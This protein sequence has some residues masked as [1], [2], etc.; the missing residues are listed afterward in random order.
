[1]EPTNE[2]TPED[3]ADV[4]ELAAAAKAADG[5]PPLN[6]EATL[7][8]VR[9]DALHWLLR[10][11]NRLCGYAQWQPSNA[12]GQL[13]VH[14]HH[15]RAQLGTALLGGLRRAAQP[16]VW[17]FGTLAP[18]RAFA[19]ARGLA[20]V[21]GLTMMRRALADEPN[22]VPP[23]GI[24]L[25]GFTAADADAFIALN[26]A[27]FAHHPE[28]GHFTA[29]DLQTR[30]AEAWW[31]PE[32]LILAIEDDQLR[33]FHWTKRHDAATGEVYVLGVAPDA[34]R[35]GLGRVLLQ[36]GLTQLTRDGATQVILYVDADNETALALYRKAGFAVVHTDTLY[37]PTGS[38]VTDA[39]RDR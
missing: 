39:V 35:R 2:L 31:D 13:V 30:Q 10:D 8:L 34:G 6:E 3:R 17:A 15:R 9:D 28:Q 38:P 21:R 14:P 20:P 33:G 7:A 29:A 18:A 26:A 27:A 23:N 11:G 1:M 5:T 12:T 37:G 24:T 32:G 22:P 4:I 16:R 19:D 36:A 25:R